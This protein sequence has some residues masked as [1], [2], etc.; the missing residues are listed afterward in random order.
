MASNN[1]APL[2]P[3]VTIDHLYFPEIMDAIF[4][5][6]DT[7]A[8]VALRGASREFRDRVDPQLFAHI[9]VSSLKEDPPSLVNWRTLVLY[10]NN[11]D[12]LPVPPMV[13]IKS[14]P[15]QTVICVGLAEAFLRTAQGLAAAL[16]TPSSEL[17]EVEDV[18]LPEF[19]LGYSCTPAQQA[20]DRTHLAGIIET[21]GRFKVVCKTLDQY[22]ATLTPAQEAAELVPNRSILKVLQGRPGGAGS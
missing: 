15:E 10:G 14:N 18:L 21:L 19:W 4:T 9:R 11:G 6:A 22:K 1:A 2:A 8:L 12:K 16:G 20:R 7:G 13:R 17:P 5:A 3:R